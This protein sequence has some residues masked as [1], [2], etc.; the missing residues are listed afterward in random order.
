MTATR[1]GVTDRRLSLNQLINP[2]PQIVDSH[3]GVCSRAGLDRRAAG[4]AV[5]YANW[6]TGEWDLLKGS[7]FDFHSHLTVF[8]LNENHRVWT[9][10]QQICEAY[11]EVRVPQENRAW[12]V[13]RRIIHYDRVLAYD[14]IGD[15]YNEGPHLLVDY[16]NGEPFENRLQVLVMPAWSTSRQRRLTCRPVRTTPNVWVLSR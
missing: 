6:Q 3:W 1:H 14:G 8:G 11:W 13:E 9:D 4:V 5:A 12:L 2:G 15:S 10:A 7:D 16:L